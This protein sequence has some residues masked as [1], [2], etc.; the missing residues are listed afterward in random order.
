MIRHF[1][2]RSCT[3][4]IVLTAAFAVGGIR[5][6]F[7]LDY[8]SW[9]AT[10]I[11]VVTPLGDDGK[12]QVLEA[13][14]GD[15]RPGTI[16]AIPD[17]APDADSVPIDQ[18]PQKPYSDDGKISTKV[19]VVFPGSKIVLYMKDNSGASGRGETS[20]WTASNLFG[21]MKASAVWIHEGMAYG[22]VQVS[23]PGESVLVNLRYVTDPNPSATRT[24]NLSESS[25]KE[26]TFNVLRLQ[27]QIDAAAAIQDPTA[28]AEALKAYADSKIRPAKMFV[29]E[30]LGKCGE[31]ALPTIGSMMDDPKFSKDAA[32]LI[33]QY[34]KAGG[35]GV[36]PQLTSR[37]EADLRYWQAIGPT[38][39]VGWWNLIDEHGIWADI[40]GYRDRYSQTIALVR[41]LDKL[42]YLPAVSTAMQLRDFWKSW[43]Q[44]ND[45]SG[46]NQMSDAADQLVQ[47]L[48]VGNS[49]K[50]K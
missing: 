8:S 34:A 26:R 15:L 46:L 38:L 30:E 13:W 50:P 49:E 44:L 25:L 40:H 31:A 41:A 10:D 6:S 11:V 43:P 35:T 23:N 18:Y 42:R 32:E 47:H 28:R 20:R 4:L 24:E 45:P 19:P 22:F 5:P 48:Q 12:F 14:K 21:D 36:G 33:E 3:L 16:I 29:L 17:L 9:Y 39:P 37:L 27:H 2:T 7:M 1:G